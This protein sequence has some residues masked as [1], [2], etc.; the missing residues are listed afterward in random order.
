[1]RDQKNRFWICILPTACSS[2]LCHPS[3]TLY[4]CSDWPE[5][6]VILARILFAH[7]FICTYFWKMTIKNFQIEYDSINSQNIFTNGD[8]INGRIVVEVSKET[9]I[10]SLT[11]IGKGS[12]K[13]C[14]HEYYGQHSSGYYWSDEKYYEIKQH[15]LRA[16]NACFI[17]YFSPQCWSRSFIRIKHKLPDISHSSRYWFYSQRK[18]CVP[19]FLQ[20]P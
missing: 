8:T 14:W 12:A 15:I 1:M 3:Q 9:A 7:L 18:T 5:A 11:F 19:L 6:L 2:P 10:Q 13:V 17:H 20:G 16:G 4:F